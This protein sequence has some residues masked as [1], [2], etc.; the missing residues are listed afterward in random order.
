MER[1]LTAAEIEILK[2]RLLK[3]KRDLWQE[4]RGHLRLE[5]DEEYQD[6]LKIPL[7]EEDKAVVDLK[8]ETALSLIEPK[9]RELEE[10][11][12]ALGRIERG[13]YG[14]C[15]DCGGPISVKRLEIM[16]ETPRCARCQAR[17][18]KIEKKK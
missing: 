11:E 4:V 17:R 15:T 14:R 6:L 10:I 5:V 13:E 9:K 2:E 18:E 16:P 7:D 8:E 12:E 1:K 3:R